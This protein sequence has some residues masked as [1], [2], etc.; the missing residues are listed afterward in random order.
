M[1][2]NNLQTMEIAGNVVEELKEIKRMQEDAPY[3][4]SISTST[5]GEYLTI[6]CC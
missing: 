1:K 5:C 4:L 2:E 3:V 6:I